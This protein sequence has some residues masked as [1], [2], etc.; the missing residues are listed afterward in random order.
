M[1]IL[2]ILAFVFIGLASFWHSV[3]MSRGMYLILFI[4]ELPT[5]MSFCRYMTHCVQSVTARCPSQH[6]ADPVLHVF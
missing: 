5:D 6:L 1:Y 4:L 3:S 2:Y